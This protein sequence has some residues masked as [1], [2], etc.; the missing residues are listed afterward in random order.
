MPGFD[1]DEFRSRYS[2]HP[3][4]RHSRKRDPYGSASRGAIIDLLTSQVVPDDCVGLEQVIAESKPA[5][6]YRR[7]M[8]VLAQETLVKSANE[9]WLGVLKPDIMLVAVPSI[10][11]R[12]PE[13]LVKAE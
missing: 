7:R 13:A 2:P 11:E 12:P 6:L 4:M 5:I 3:K 10:G 9:C 1:A 8:F